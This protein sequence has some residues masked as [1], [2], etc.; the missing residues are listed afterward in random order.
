MK[1]LDRLFGGPKDMA[2]L[3]AGTKAPDFSLPAIFN[4]KDGG[5]FSLQ[6]A[7]KQGPVL[8]AFF[9]VSCPTCQYTFPYLE[10]IHRAHGDK[11]VTIVGISQNDQRDTTAFLK[12]YGVTFR[13]LLDDP[14]GYAVSN[15]YGLTNV[16]TLFLIGQ[17]GQIE[18]SSVGWVKQEIEDIN[19]KLAA[20]QQITLP[21]IFKPGEDV[22]DF[23]A[24]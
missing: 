21:P 17:D 22:R 3:P 8:A 15:A 9:K 1:W 10:R 14:N 19:R 23:R 13:T 24:G 18:I 2:A 20:A 12:E 5:K 6:A 4:G 11:K 7:L 16:P